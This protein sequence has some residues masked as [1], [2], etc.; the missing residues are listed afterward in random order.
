MFRVI[1]RKNSIDS[2]KIYGMIYRIRNNI[3]GGDLVSKEIL[4]KGVIKSGATTGVWLKLEGFHAW[5]DP[6]QRDF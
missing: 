1:G 4:E 2:C 5:S 6:L 3:K